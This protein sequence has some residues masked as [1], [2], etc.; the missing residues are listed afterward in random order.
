MKR[1]KILVTAGSTWVKIDAVRVVANRFTGRTGLELARRFKALG[2]AVTLLVNPHC[3][4]RE[5]KGLKTEEFRYYNEL[6][7]KTRALLKKQ[8]FD[9]IVHTAAVSDYLPLR[10]CRGKI[11]SGRPGLAVKF[12]P[13]PKIIA[14]MRRLAPAASIVQFK[15]EKDARGLVKKAYAS[16]KKN[17]SDR[18]VANALDNIALKQVIDREK[19]IIKVRS[20]KRLAAVLLKAPAQKDFA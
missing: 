17:K 15:L 6:R 7:E 3:L 10:P 9:M 2:C 5:L 19:N 11:A 12:R 14:L 20:L 18:V 16:L 13:A 8:R 4:S 1:K